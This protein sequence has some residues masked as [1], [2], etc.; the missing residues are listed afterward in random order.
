MESIK[1]NEKKNDL[2]NLI[3]ETEQNKNEE[4]KIYLIQYQSG[5]EFSKCKDKN[6]FDLYAKT[7][8]TIN[9]SMEDA[10][11]PNYNYDIDLKFFN[12]GKLVRKIF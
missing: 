9:Q 1:Q 11:F 3:N 2:N 12:E 6:E 7:V 10:I 5:M 8:E 4:Q